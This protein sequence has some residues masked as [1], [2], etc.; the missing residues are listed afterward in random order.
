MKF[1][2]IPISLLFDFITSVR[3]FLFDYNILKAEKFDIPIIC[4]G[5]LSLGGTGKTPHIN[6]I[7][8]ELSKMFNVAVISRGYKRS[9]ISRRW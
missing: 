5:N 1:L 4:V 3:N 7:I 2:F 9:W 6:Y 8:K